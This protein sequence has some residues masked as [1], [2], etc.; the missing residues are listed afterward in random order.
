M[1]LRKP[2]MIRLASCVGARVLR[3]WLSTIRCRADWFDPKLEPLNPSLRERY[4]YAMW[5]EQLLGMLAFRSAA[6]VTVLVS[7]SAEG[8]LLAQM[9]ARFG[10]N[11]VRGSSTHGAL[12]TVHE[13]LDLNMQS[14]LIVASD[15]QR[16]P[17]QDVKR[18]L[19]YLSA[20]T[21]LPIVPLGLAFRRA[22]RAKS[23]DR[24][25]VPVP[26]TKLHLVGG[27]IITVPQG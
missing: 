4:I 25:A 12:D 24:M 23:W 10:V 21:N 11:T 8:D 26:G 13:V 27:P 6:P 3:A 16:G 18:W 9:L 2:W 22:W 19:V 5:H 1:K 17:R 14:H 20:W 7:Q 15:G